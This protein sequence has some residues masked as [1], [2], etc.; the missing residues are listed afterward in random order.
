MPCAEARGEAEEEH[1]KP[2]K[3][4]VFILIVAKSQWK[5]LIYIQQVGWDGMWGGQVTAAGL[6]NKLEMGDKRCQ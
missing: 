2:Q 6:G 5:I 1:E 4:L 3:N